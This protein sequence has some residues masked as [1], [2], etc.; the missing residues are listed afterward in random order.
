MPCPT[1]STPVTSETGPVS[2]GGSLLPCHIQGPQERA[3]W[4]LGS[5]YGRQADTKFWVEYSSQQVPTSQTWSQPS[6]S[7]ASSFETPSN[8]QLLSHKHTT[9]PTPTP[10]HLASF[11]SLPGAQMCSSLFCHQPI[12]VTWESWLL[13]ARQQ[14]LRRQMMSGGQVLSVLRTLR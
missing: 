4:G 14:L 8:P 13:C 2:Y 10:N 3:Q 6:P 9:R 12:L 5:Q 7:P 1:L 11:G